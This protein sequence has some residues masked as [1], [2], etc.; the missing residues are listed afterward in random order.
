M[1]FLLPPKLK[2]VMDAMI[3]A[4]H[5]GNLTQLNKLLENNDPLPVH[6]DLGGKQNTACQRKAPF[7]Q[8]TGIYLID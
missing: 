5:A 2:Q 6:T 1:K 7:I 4:N 3:Y 8:K